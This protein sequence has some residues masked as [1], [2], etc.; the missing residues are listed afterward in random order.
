[1]TLRELKNTVFRDVD[2]IC[3]HEYSDI[4]FPIDG[5]HRFPNVKKAKNYFGKKEVLEVVDDEPS[6]TTRIYLQG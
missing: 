1:M 2:I 3:V 5:V 6:R 4:M